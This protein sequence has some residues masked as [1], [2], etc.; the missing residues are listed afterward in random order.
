[1][2]ECKYD[3][4]IDTEKEFMHGDGDLENLPIFQGGFINWGYYDTVLEGDM[5]K[6]VRIQASKRL[7]E[8]CTSH[9]GLQHEDKF[10]ELGAAKV[11]GCHI[12]KNITFLI[13]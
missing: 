3:R 5:S 7:Y 12:L 13:R 11:S 1:M 9:L 4:R 8:V 2:S 10:L 6:D